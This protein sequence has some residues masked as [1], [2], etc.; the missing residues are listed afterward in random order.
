MMAVTISGVERVGF[1]AI[2]AFLFVPVW[3][4]E[5]EALRQE[6]FEVPDGGCPWQ[7]DLS[8]LHAATTV[9]Q[10]RWMLQKLIRGPFMVAPFIAIL[11]KVIIPAVVRALEWASANF[12]TNIRCLAIPRMIV[13]LLALIFSY[14]GGNLGCCQYAS[15]GSPWSEPVVIRLGTPRGDDNL[16]CASEEQEKK[17]LE[18]LKSEILPQA[19]R[20]CWEPEGELLELKMS[21][22][23]VLYCT[24]LLPVGAI[25][26]L[27]GRMV[28]VSFDLGKMLH[29]R[30][31]SWPDE[32]WSDRRIQN[33]FIFSTAVSSIGWMYGLWNVTYATESGEFDD[34]SHA[35]ISVG[36]MIAPFA[37]MF[38][39]IA[40]IGSKGSEKEKVIKLQDSLR[41]R[42]RSAN[43]NS[44]S[45]ANGDR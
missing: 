17:M 3:P 37:V 41:K 25:F 42:S 22:L 28:E 14:D 27:I 36:T 18:E 29:V 24:P 15:R 12:G 34:P 8:C 1:I 35:V 20:K 30:R 21:F 16:P 38:V 26:T 23:W 39:Y 6:A 32:D 7:L 10:R 2:L 43:S 19:A 4:T 44:A 40:T 11:V 45:S 13:R 5:Q 33:I 9:Q 31:R